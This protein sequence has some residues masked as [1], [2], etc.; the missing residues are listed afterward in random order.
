MKLKFFP[1]AGVVCYPPGT[2]YPGQHHP[3]IGR[4]IV[5]IPGSVTRHPA[6]PEGAEIDSENAAAGRYVEHCQREAL[7]AGDV[8]TARHCGVAF[9]EVVQGADGEWIPKPPDTEPGRK[10]PRREP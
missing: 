1:R 10:T 2:K 5:N 4:S 6:L 7:W 9:V 3:Y 8:D